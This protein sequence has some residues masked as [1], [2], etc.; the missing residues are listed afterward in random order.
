MNKC[1]VQF[2]CTGSKG[3]CNFYKDIIIKPARYHNGCE[4]FANGYCTNKKAQIDTLIQEGFLES[5]G[6]NVEIKED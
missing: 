6:K 2:V 4:H 5:A 1:Y 3:F